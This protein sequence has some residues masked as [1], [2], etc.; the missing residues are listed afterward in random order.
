MQP[1]AYINTVIDNQKLLMKLTRVQ[2]KMTIRI[3]SAYRTV[4][5]EEAGVLSGVPPIELLI[6]ERKEKYSCSK[7]HV[8]M[9]KQMEPWKIRY[10]GTLDSEY[11]GMD[12]Q[13][14]WKYLL[15]RRRAQSEECPY[16]RAQDNG[17]LPLE[18]VASK[19]SY[20][21]PVMKEIW[22]SLAVAGG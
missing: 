7:C 5:A 14:I 10:F 13:T 15:D 2:R 8:E 3:C 6:Q 1:V 12:R 9:A 21:S 18:G 16:C 4:S 11:T 22:S 20:R 17:E 19:K